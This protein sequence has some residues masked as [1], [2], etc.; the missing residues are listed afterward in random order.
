MGA[1]FIG[2]SVLTVIP[3]LT[4]GFANGITALGVVLMACSGAVIWRRNR[5]AQ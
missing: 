5:S 4:L 2:S 1:M 3:T